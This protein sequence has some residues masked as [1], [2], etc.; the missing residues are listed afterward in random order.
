[1]AIQL[2]SEFAAVEVD[3]DDNGNG[4]RLMIRDL[5]SGRQVFL[6]PLEVAALAW[7]RHEELL[8][9]LDPARLDR[10]GRRL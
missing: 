5:R 10:E 1:M 7:T 6:D 3:R 9:L 4:P 2:T 8:P